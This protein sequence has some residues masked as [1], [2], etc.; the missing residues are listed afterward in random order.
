MRARRPRIFSR[1]KII[2]LYAAGGSAAD[3]ARE[4]GCSL[5]TVR[6][7]LKGLPK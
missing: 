3:I 4:V 2:D 5:S 7:A 1:S 6:R